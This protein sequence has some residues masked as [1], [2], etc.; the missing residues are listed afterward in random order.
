MTA[1]NEHNK[2]I[3]EL[4]DKAISVFGKYMKAMDPDKHK[5][6]SALDYDYNG[7]FRT[8][9]IYFGATSFVCVCNNGEKTYAIP[10]K[11]LFNDAS[12][13][14]LSVM[15]GSLKHWS[16][17]SELERDAINNEERALNTVMS[18]PK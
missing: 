14:V 2:S 9:D 17:M 10:N 7:A 13:A 4:T 12:D 11:F 1:L 16:T 15:Q 18:V 6:L 8:L 5:E 3:K